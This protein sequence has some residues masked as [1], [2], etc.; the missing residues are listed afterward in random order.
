VKACPSSSRRL[1]V[2]ASLLLAAAPATLFAGGMALTMQNGAHLAHA[3]SAGAAAE[4]ASTVYF[5]PAGLASISRP[6]V[7]AGST[8]VM[9]DGGFTN[10]GSLTVGMLPTAGADDDDAGQDSAVP[11]IYIAIPLASSWFF[12]FGASSPFGLRTSYDEGWVGRYHA[13]RSKLETINLN[14][15]IAWR[16]T[17]RL[18]LGLGFDWQRADATLT[19]AVDFGLIGFLNGV[20]GLLPG[21]LDGALRVSGDDS[22]TGFNAG[23]LLEVADGARIGVHFRSKMTHDISGQA[24]FSNVPA[25]FAPLFPDQTA[26]A[27]LSL[28]E[29]VSVSY[30]QELSPSLAVMADWS[31]WNWSRF[32]SLAIDFENPLT[33]DIVQRQNWTDASIYSLGLRWRSSSRFLWRAGLAYN[34]SPVRSAAFRSAR[35]PD[36]DRIWLGLGTAVRLSDV[37]KIDVGYAHLF[38]KDTTTTNDDGV[39]HALIGNY[40]MSADIVSAQLTW[41]F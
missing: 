33:Q 40:S 6:E 29:I 14:P 21:E 20:P 7:I 17:E 19:N 10:T 27:R 11:S 8:Y 16:A 24:T 25:P 13:L 12:G 38:I 28:P 3:Y 22:T 32:E 4:D 34:E 9:F 5:N 30:F 31:W 26:S 41:G 23:A 36:S 37:A 2:V 35:I 1:R 18:S 15:A 39:G